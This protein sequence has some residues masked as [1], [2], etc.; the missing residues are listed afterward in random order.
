MSLQQEG[1]MVAKR[2]GAIGGRANCRAAADQPERAVVVV[3]T[4]DHPPCA[5]RRS[6]REDITPGSCNDRKEEATEPG[7]TI[8]ALWQKSL[9]AFDASLVILAGTR[10]EPSARLQL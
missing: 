9:T 1:R 8:H 3:A 5:Q 6:C 2:G 10:L 7:R 4:L